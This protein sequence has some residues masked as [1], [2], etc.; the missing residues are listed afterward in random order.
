MC[1]PVDGGIEIDVYGNPHCGP[2]YCVRDQYGK[3][4]C[5]STPRGA[6][7]LDRDGK[8]VCTDGCIPGRADACVVP[9][10]EKTKAA[11]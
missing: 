1:S 5:S 2:G 6:S 7:S 9:R 3:V 11:R 10:P 8:P 4:F